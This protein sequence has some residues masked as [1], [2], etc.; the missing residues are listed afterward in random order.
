MLK[1]IFKNIYAASFVAS[2][3]SCITLTQIFGAKHALHINEL[4]SQGI[5]SNG[6]INLF[7]TGITILLAIAFILYSKKKLDKPLDLIKF[8]L[9]AYM[10]FTAVMILVIYQGGIFI[11]EN[12]FTIT[13][14]LLAYVIYESLLFILP[15]IVWGIIN[16]IYSMDKKKITYVVL[17]LVISLITIITPLVIT[18]YFATLF[19]D[20]ELKPVVISLLGLGLL[21]LFISKWVH[22]IPKNSDAEQKH[23]KANKFP[24]IKSTLLLMVVTTGG[25]FTLFNSIFLYFVYS[26]KQD[27]LK[28]AFDDSNYLAIILTSSTI[29]AI[30]L[31]AF[32][33]YSLRKKSWRFALQGSIIALLLSCVLAFIVVT[34][35]P[36]WYLFTTV[37]IHNFFGSVRAILIFPIIQMLYLYLPVND[38]FNMKLKIEMICVPVV[39]LLITN[40]ITFIAKSI[41]KNDSLI[42]ISICI[43]AALM[44]AALWAS[45]K[46]SMEFKHYN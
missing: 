39:I 21:F 4:I 6:L 29:I 22:N 18:S 45:K 34:Y 12:N 23:I 1:K 40:G 10:L 30:L 16:T 41:G 9:K 44:L 25:V 5:I 26:Q 46:I 8:I 7:T 31:F 14:R 15:L 17:S 2:F 13:I 38:R 33:E 19:Y 36:A 43:A 24:W 3:I 11:T 20:T 27:L 42:Y 32:T 37:T 28:P 35:M